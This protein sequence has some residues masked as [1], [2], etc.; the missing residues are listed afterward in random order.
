M[1]AGDNDEM[2]EVK[3][4]EVKLCKN[5]SAVSEGGPA[6]ARQKRKSRH[7]TVSCRIPGAREHYVNFFSHRLFGFRRVGSVG[8]GVV[9]CRLPVV[10]DNYVIFFSH[11]IFFPALAAV[12]ASA[13]F[14]AH[15]RAPASV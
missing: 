3:G 9:S 12:P 7:G 15:C 2:V 8:I 10:A 13:S 6:R 14:V 1:R 11:R 4:K 5:D